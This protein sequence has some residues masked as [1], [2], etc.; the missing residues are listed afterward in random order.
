MQGSK[1]T[2]VASFAAIEKRPSPPAPLPWVLGGFWVHGREY[3]IV[4]FPPGVHPIGSI[5]WA[6]FSAWF[7]LRS[8]AR[9]YADQRMQ[10]TTLIEQTN[11][12]KYANS[13][14]GCFVSYAL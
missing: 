3:E 2:R 1:T 4:C 13:C 14:N 11:A 12:S 7:I 6:A 8:V 9:S 5:F 10:V